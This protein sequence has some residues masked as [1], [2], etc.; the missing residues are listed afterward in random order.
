MVMSQRADFGNSPARCSIH[1]Y[2]F[3]VFWFLSPFKA[4]GKSNKALVS[5]G[6]WKLMI[7]FFL[8]VVNRGLKKCFFSG[9]LVSCLILV[10]ANESPPIVSD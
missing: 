3:A 6:S 4:Y 2:Y 1:G 8:K 10:L 7:F 9:D 5:V